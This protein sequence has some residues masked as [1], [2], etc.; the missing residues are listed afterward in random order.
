VKH[1]YP[2]QIASAVTHEQIVRVPVWILRGHSFSAY[3]TKFTVLPSCFAF[4][5]QVNESAPHA[6]PEIAC[7]AE[8]LSDPCRL[9]ASR[10]SRRKQTGLVGAVGIE[11]DPV[12]LSPA[13]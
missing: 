13:N 4:K 9:R 8:R 7:V 5:Y 12:F 10:V 2:P 3:Y 1:S 11:H 6:R